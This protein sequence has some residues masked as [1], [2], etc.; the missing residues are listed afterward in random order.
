MQNQ[1]TP[2]IL[3]REILAQIKISTTW[4]ELIMMGSSVY[5]NTSKMR[6]PQAVGT[7]LYHGQQCKAFLMIFVL[8]LLV[9]VVVVGSADPTASVLQQ[10]IQMLFFA[11]VLLDFSH[12]PIQQ[13]VRV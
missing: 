12:G 9:I 7:V 13:L 10:I 2:L 4:L 3:Q 6:M 1:A 5:T 11:N 8:H